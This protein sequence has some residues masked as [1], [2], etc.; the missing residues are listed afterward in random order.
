MPPA[1]S[2]STT[3][4]RRTSPVTSSPSDPATPVAQDAELDQSVHVLRSAPR[5]ARRALAVD[6]APW[7]DS[8]GQPRPPR[9]RL[10]RGR[11]RKSS[12]AVLLPQSRGVSMDPAGRRRLRRR[13]PA[14]GRAARAA[15]RAPRA[16][17][18][19]DSTIGHRRAAIDLDPIAGRGRWTQPVTG[20][21]G[22]ER[23]VPDRP[24][25]GRADRPGHQLPGDTDLD[26]PDRGQGGPGRDQRSL[27]GGRAHR[28]RGRCDPGGPRRRPGRPT[29]RD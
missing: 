27:Q 16:V 29:A 9:Q 21:D 5:P 12:P 25:R 10:R 13:R 11:R 4:I 23:P 22:V 28:R 1:S 18:R 19:A 7:R 15:R 14:C 24:D 6:P 26:G 3:R 2:P 17:S 20:R 8:V